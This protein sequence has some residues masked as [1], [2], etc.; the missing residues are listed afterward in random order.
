MLFVIGRNVICSP[1]ESSNI[2]TI[3][4]SFTRKKNLKSCEPHLTFINR[5]IITLRDRVSQSAV[6]QEGE[7]EGAD[8][9]RAGATARKTGNQDLREGA[10]REAWR[11]NPVL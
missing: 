4:F 7:G 3:H 9:L 8:N 10:G 2:V 1:K 11:R 5:K 6:N